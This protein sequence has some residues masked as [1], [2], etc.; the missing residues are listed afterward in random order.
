M[1]G[2]T[3]RLLAFGAI[4]VAAA[5]FSAGSASAYQFD[6]SSTRGKTTQ[7][8]VD[9]KRG[10]EIVRQNSS[11]PCRYGETWG[12]D[13][14]MVWVSNGCRATFRINEKSS[15]SGDAAAA[16]IALGII[17]GLAAASKKHDR[18]DYG[19]YDQPSQLID[20]SSGDRRLTR[21][22]VRIPNSAQIVRQYSSA[23]CTYGT[24]WGYD[25]RGIW[26]DK[27]CRAQFAVY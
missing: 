2:F 12:Y 16:I 20:C 17:A 18:P 14:R 15:S 8:P 13:R 5:V 27:G 7:C 24:S 4:S 6:C 22:R 9:T 23:S 1:A 26:V 21:C 10:V 11:A 3:F 19:D 25:R